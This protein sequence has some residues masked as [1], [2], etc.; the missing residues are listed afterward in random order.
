MKKS[1]KKIRSKTAVTLLLL[2]SIGLTWLASMVC[3]TMTT[4]QSIYDNLYNASY[5]FVDNVHGMGGF[6]RFYDPE[7]SHT[8][9]TL[10]ERPDY[11]EY[12]IFSAI[13]GSTS[14][15]ISSVEH[16]SYTYSYRE[17]RDPWLR[18]IRYPM[19]TAVLFYDGE[20]NL[21]HSSEDDIMFFDYNTQEEWDVGDDSAA[22]QHY[23]W[24]DISEGK[25]EGYP[26][27]PYLR[28]R[29]IFSN[30]GSRFWDYTFRM[31]GTFE[32]NCFVPVRMDFVDRW[33]VISSIEED[34]KQQFATGDGG[35]SYILSDVE[36][37]GLLEWQMQFDRTDEYTGDPD[38]LVTIYA[39]YPKMWDYEETPL[40][41]NGQEYTSLAHLTRELEVPTHYDIYQYSNDLRAKGVYKLNEL[42]IFTGWEY[43]EY[44]NYPSGDAPTDLI[45]VTAVRSNPLACA[46][47]AL[48]NIYIVTG[49]LALALFL[50]VYSNIKKRLVEPVA[51]VAAAMEDGWRNIHRPKDAPTMWAEA[52]ELT[53]EFKIEQDRRRMKNNE[54][55]RLNTALEYAKTA[56]QNRRQMTSSI[57]HELKT[58]L[59]VIHSY[60]EGLKEHI[61]EDRR[62][63]YLDVIL[64]EVK[65]TDGMVLE[66]LDLSRLEAGK[67]K[68]ARD[69]FSLAE[70]TRS[71][72]GKLE[73]ALQSKNLHLEYH[74]PEQSMV[75]ADETRI[76]QVIENF[77]TNAI[78]YTPDGG[79]ITVVIRTGQSLTTLTVENESAPLPWEALNKVW[80]TFYRADDSRS[81]GGTGLGLA[82]A[83]SIID[84]HGG[85]CFVHNT[86]MGVEFG[87][88]L[89]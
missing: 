6:T 80:D 21:L 36:R 9:G 46:M 15:S 48:R 8:Y 43:A 76:A 59:A 25:E 63:Q 39:H 32:G 4:A 41:Y 81:G 60:A 13:E 47:S 58:P 16:Y 67:V 27:D 73:R 22:A 26:N 84:L 1:K 24:I 28:L 65:R 85:T 44:A 29:N 74:L 2:V 40:T 11:M 35:Y 42:L 33:S 57:A 78:K 64:S 18:D 69:E 82:I 14:S 45:L 51:D 62:D 10:D 89:K 87:F 12:C 79:R 75:T 7:F 23:G 38:N 77:A 54:I 19:E 88:T 34:E 56:E 49:I 61:A 83:K 68:L 17:E 37:A 5:N 50:V 20:G 30:H 55:A 86:A 31:T 71:V 66:M 53:S 70:L 72:F 52:D 3:L